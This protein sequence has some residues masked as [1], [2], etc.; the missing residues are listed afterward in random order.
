MGLG[1][2][3]FVGLKKASFIPSYSNLCMNKVLIHQN[4]N[5]TINNGL[6]SVPIFPEPV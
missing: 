3:S 6:T 1:L 4:G 5:K 2:H